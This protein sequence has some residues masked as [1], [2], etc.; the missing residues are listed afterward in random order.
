[1][2]IPKHRYDEIFEIEVDGWCYA[3]TRFPGE[4]SASIVHRLIKEFSP[5]L[6]RAVV[7]HYAFNPLS[8]AQRLSKAAKYLVSEKEILFCLLTHLPRPDVLDEEAQYVLAMIV[9]QAE[10]VYGGVLTRLERKWKGERMAAAKTKAA[11]LPEVLPQTASAVK[12]PAVA[13]RPPSATRA[14]PAKAWVAQGY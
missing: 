4:I 3:I 5:S 2:I 14:T 10:R 13:F 9:D 12:A 1:M 6:E 8:V 11:A 7:S